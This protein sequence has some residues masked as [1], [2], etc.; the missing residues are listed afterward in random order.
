MHTGW[1]CVTDVCAEARVC[2]GAGWSCV[3]WGRGGDGHRVQGGAAAVSG[4]QRSAHRFVTG[5]GRGVSRTS[6]QNGRAR[7]ETIF[8]SACPRR[9]VQAPVQWSEGGGGHAGVGRDPNWRL[10][11]GSCGMNTGL[12]R[13]MWCTSHQ[14]AHARPRTLFVSTCTEAI[15]KARGRGG[16]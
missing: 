7:P 14:N 6:S 2:V 9:F 8:I 11:V 13:V 10:V 16:A 4:G 1:C 3:C 12:S 15:L 5:L